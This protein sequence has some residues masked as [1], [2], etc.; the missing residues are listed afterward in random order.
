MRITT[1]QGTHEDIERL[2]AAAAKNVGISLKFGSKPRGGVRTRYINILLRPDGDS[3]CKM[4]FP[5]PML[6]DW[7]RKRI[8]SVCWKGWIE[9]FDECFRLAEL[10]EF[11]IIIRA[12]GLSKELVGNNRTTIDGAEHWSLVRSN[13][14]QRYTEPQGHPSNEF[15]EE[16]RCHCKVTG[17]FEC[18]T[19]AEE[20][21]IA[22]KA[23]TKRL[24]EIAKEL[25]EIVFTD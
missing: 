12:A 2:A 24:H 10:L 25:E 17:K 22:E 13:F 7:S 6:A 19:F 15:T 20:L 16:S 21:E 23:K 4:N 1:R 8:A 3:F 11:E 14:F 5:N 9:F 18:R